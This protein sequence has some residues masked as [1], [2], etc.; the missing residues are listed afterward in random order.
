MLNSTPPAVHAQHIFSLHSGRQKREKNLEEAPRPGSNPAPFILS[1]FSLAL[2]SNPIYPVL[3]TYSHAHSHHTRRLALRLSCPAQLP[4][5]LLSA[6]IRP[7][8]SS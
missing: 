6:H 2:S 1:H 7:Q 3:R 8:F 4:L 5:S